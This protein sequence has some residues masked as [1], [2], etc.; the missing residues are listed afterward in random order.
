MMMEEDDAT[1]TV[2]TDTVTCL[3][4]FSGV[5]VA[6]EV[7]AA[8]EMGGLDQV[9]ME[10]AE[11]SSDEE[12]QWGGSVPGKSPNLNR[13]FDE[14]YRRLKKLYFSGEES[15]YTEGMFKRRFRVSPATFQRVYDAVVGKGCF[16]PPDHVDATGKP[17][18]HPLVRLT[19]VFRTLC[20]GTPA[21]CADENWQMSETI[22]NEA[23]K[24]F[25]KILIQ[26]FGA[27]YLN[28]TP[29]EQEKRRILA[30]N[31]SKGF[32]G[33]FASW[34]CKIL[35]GINVQ[36]LFKANIKGT[37]MEESTPRFWKQ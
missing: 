16:H 15:V 29:N 5:A 24:S 20:Y 12:K 25:C 9:L 8:E 27:T 26:E 14:S 23:L 17:V 11:S 10:L 35:F 1:D 36:L 18:I 2:A 32:P 7:I 4:G 3:T 31:K 21:D 13:D 22:A 33:C 37:L 19:A 30:V 6:A 34:D 28:R